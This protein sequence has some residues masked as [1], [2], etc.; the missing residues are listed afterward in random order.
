MANRERDEEYEDNLDNYSEE[1][2][3]DLDDL[4]DDELLDLDGD[5]ED[6]AFEDEVDSVDDD[7]EQEDG[8]FEEEDEGNE[9]D[10][11]LEEDEE[12]VEEVADSEGDGEN[13]GGGSTVL[14]I[15]LSVLA[16]SALLFNGI[17]GFYLFSDGQGN[18]N[19]AFEHASAPAEN[20]DV[21]AKIQEQQEKIK[22]LQAT[23]DSLRQAFLDQPTSEDRT[24]AS[25]PDTE[26]PVDNRP[27]S[28]Y[29]TVQIG[30]FEGV[31]L[32]QFEDGLLNLE[33]QREEGLNKFRIGRYEDPDQAAALAE[34]LRKIGI[35]DA[36]IVKIENGERVPYDYNG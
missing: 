14:L 11:D 17:L 28:T 23:N 6:D 2:D 12:S 32:S 24:T 22:S 34:A 26:P 19:F 15:I 9:E 27:T 36:F 35:E 13:Q 21:S 31:D 8:N 7:D 30:A 20:E 33:Q 4:D 25:E 5:D 16:G 10:E 3:D 29:F 1:D 18:W